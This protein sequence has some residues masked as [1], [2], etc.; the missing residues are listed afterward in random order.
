MTKASK[1]IKEHPNETVYYILASP[2]KKKLPPL[3]CQQNY[4]TRKDS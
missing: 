3:H 4:L 1:K 2:L